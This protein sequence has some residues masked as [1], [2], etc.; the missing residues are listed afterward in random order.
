MRDIVDEE[1]FLNY[2]LNPASTHMP[3]WYQPVDIDE[4]F[5]RWAE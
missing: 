4:D 2:R 5:R 3:D 1:V